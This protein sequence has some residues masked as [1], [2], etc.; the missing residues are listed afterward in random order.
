MSKTVALVVMP[1]ARTI[2]ICDYQIL[3][4]YV[5]GGKKYILYLETVQDMETR[6]TASKK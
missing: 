6:N 5:S 4:P 1:I 3:W 2:R